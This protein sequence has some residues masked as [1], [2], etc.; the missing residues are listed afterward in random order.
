LLAFSGS[1]DN[2]IIAWDVI[3]SELLYSLEGHTRM[4]TGL[5]YSSSLLASCSADRTIRIWS[6]LDGNCNNII[7]DQSAE[8]TCILFV[9]SANNDNNE[10]NGDMDVKLIC[11]GNTHGTISIYNALSGDRMYKF[12]EYNSSL[13][14]LT[15]YYHKMTTYLLATTQYGCLMSYDIKSAIKG[16]FFGKLNIKE[17]IN[18]NEDT[19]FWDKRPNSNELFDSPTYVLHSICSSSGAVVVAGAD[20]LLLFFRSQSFEKEYIPPPPKVSRKVYRNLSDSNIDDNDDD[21]SISS[22]SRG[23]DRNNP[24]IYKSMKSNKSMSRKTSNTGGLLSSSK[25]YTKEDMFQLGLGKPNP[26]SNSRMQQLISSNNDDNNNTI[27]ETSPSQLLPQLSPIRL[28]DNKSNNPTNETLSRSDNQKDNAN[29]SN[30]VYSRRASF[31]NN[32]NVDDNLGR[33][34]PRS[35]SS[36]DTKKVMFIKKDNGEMIPI[37]VQTQLSDIR[38]ASRLGRRVIQPISSLSTPSSIYFSDNNNTN[39]L[40]DNQTQQMNTIKVSTTTVNLFENFC[41]EGDKKTLGKLK[42]HNSNRIATRKI[43]KCYINKY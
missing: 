28:R 42:S 32:S 20:G 38:K 2:T 16:P 5:D 27:D 10:N 4:V 25:S 33:Y 9:K 17:E 18:E 29:Q 22:K 6:T 26:L 19:F 8:I 12:E 30:E 13:S 23:Y 21:K 40:N 15:L 3:S 36:N 37:P 31:Q 43:V 14:S 39:N 1:D 41:E 24:H 7:S 11:S 35:S 34:P